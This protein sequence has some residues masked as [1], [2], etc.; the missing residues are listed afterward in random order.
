M[1]L[2]N[3]Y[4]R[5]SQLFLVICIFFTWNIQITLSQLLNTTEFQSFVCNETND[6]YDEC[7]CYLS[8]WTSDGNYDGIDISDMNDNNIKCWNKFNCFIENTSDTISFCNGNG[9]CD[10]TT[11]TC[12]CDKEYWD[13][14]CGQEYKTFV[15]PP[16]IMIGMI[17]I[18]AILLLVSLSL[19]IWVH[20]YRDVGDVKA[21]SV[22]F[23][24]LTLIGCALVSAG[25]IVIGIGYN[26]VNCMILEWFQFLGVWYV[27]YI[28]AITCFRNDIRLFLD[29]IYVQLI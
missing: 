25:C 12:E 13:D 28:L 27:T 18:G 5:I 1:L 9:Y 29:L 2:L 14:D 4:C 26:E 8:F 6:Y 22:V 11:A 19:M 10:F 3:H 20:L 23:T 17:V 21:M 24:H 15:P 7:S 16:V